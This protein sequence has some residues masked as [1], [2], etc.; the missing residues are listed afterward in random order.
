[1]KSRIIQ[2]AL[3]AAIAALLLVASDKVLYAHGDRDAVLNSCSVSPTRANPGET[4]RIR[5]KATNRNA[6][7]RSSVLYAVFSAHDLSSG[8][9]TWNQKTGEATVKK[10]KS[11]SFSAE[12]V[13]GEDLAQGRRYEITC[14]LWRVAYGAHVLQ[15]HSGGGGSGHPLSSP[16]VS[17]VNPSPRI[18]STDPS[19]RGIEVEA[20]ESVTFAAEARDAGGDIVEAAWSLN[21]DR[22]CRKTTRPSARVDTECRRRFNSEGDHRVEVRFTDSDGGSATHIWEVEVEERVAPPEWVYVSP[23]QA[24][25][26]LV[27]GESREFSAIAESGADFETVEWALDGREICAENVRAG[28]Y[29]HKS[30]CWVDAPNSAGEIELIVT[31]ED[32]EDASLSHAWRLDVTGVAPPP[33]ATGTII[34]AVNNDD[35]DA[36]I[37]EYSIDGREWRRAADAVAPATSATLV[38]SEVD[39]GPRSVNI[40]WTDPDGR[41]N[42]QMLS[43]TVAVEAGQTIWVH[44]D[45]DRNT[46]ESETGVLVV[47]VKNLYEAALTVDYSVNGGS[48]ATGGEFLPNSI[49]EELFHGIYPTGNLTVSVRWRAPLTGEL[50]EKS[51]SADILADRR[52]V[53]KFVLAPA[54]PPPNRHPTVTKLAPASE[55]LEIAVGKSVDFSIRANDPEGR[56]GFIEWLV[57]GVLVKESMTNAASVDSELRHT[58]SRPGQSRVVVVAVDSAEQTATA[59]WSVNVSDAPPPPETGELVV[60]VNNLTDDA[61]RLE[62]R[63]NYGSWR[64]GGAVP[65]ATNGWRLF[66]EEY[67][68]GEHRIAI[69]WTVRDISRTVTRIRSS[70]VTVRAGQTT[71]LV[72]TIDEGAPPPPDGDTGELRIRVKNRTSEYISGIEYAVNTEPWRRG[73]EVFGESE[74]WVEEGRRFPVGSY[75]ISLRWDGA[76]RVETQ[77]VRISKNG[78]AIATFVIEGRPVGEYGEVR[79]YLD[80]KGISAEFIAIIEQQLG[81]YFNE[82]EIEEIADAIVAGALCGEWCTSSIDKYHEYYFAGWA[83]AGFAPGINVVADGRDFLAIAAVCAGILGEDD[84]CSVGT[85]VLNGLAIIPFQAIG[86]VGGP[87]GVA[88]GFTL[89]GIVDAAQ[90]ARH[91]KKFR[92]AHPDK[93]DDG[94]RFL[95]K[96]LPRGVGTKVLS[97]IFPAETKRLTMVFHNLA[98]S[99]GERKK[100]LTRAEALTVDI[101][102]AKGDVNKAVDALERWSKSDW[103]TDVN[104]AKAFL[105]GE[106]TGLGAVSEIDVYEW[107]K[108]LNGVK[109]GVDSEK[110]IKLGTRDVKPVDFAIPASQLPAINKNLH[111]EVYRMDKASLP[112]FAKTIAAD[113][114]RQVARTLETDPDG[115][116]VVVA[117]V[118]AH[119]LD[120]L[121]GGSNVN[122]LLN[123]NFANA[124][125]PPLKGIHVVYKDKSGVDSALTYY[126][127]GNAPDSWIYRK[128]HPKPL[129]WT[130]GFTGGEPVMQVGQLQQ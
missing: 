64:S 1:M 72:F 107:L 19:E 77:T 36:L 124:L 76:P 16:V 29:R 112:N 117:D 120:S 17:V 24:S 110:L 10:G 102:I 43:K 46:G 70:T 34:V 88:A 82:N 91:Y 39:A 4:V 79:E 33:P 105:S 30:E 21:G 129:D 48:W 116:G 62:Y 12:V 37:V 113:K 108:P 52:A 15:E 90:L 7:L 22:V 28:R 128:D 125:S 121:P 71:Q 93:V 67:D 130:D 92:K 25:L 41:G 6:G 2:F 18:V 118:R 53:V 115:L 27:A 119:R 13:A 89:D 51:G 63:A 85:F 101:Y 42:Q 65:A 45:L 114:A 20:G 9:K 61:V 123:E 104:F 68:V 111:I 74:A 23:P 81:D 31:F 86:V 98:T 26:R 73:S 57:D 100:A 54:Q 56:L 8:R 83:L 69:Q 96:V 58:F 75:L 127:D 49:F 109:I 99:S 40:R 38:R 87:V 11:R 94:L 126:R 84:D 78:L 44:F 3:A 47:G 32:S 97:L 80:E 122:E 35:D 95:L 14:G 106:K 66:S 60:N 59:S 5:A 55:R 103:E 50:N